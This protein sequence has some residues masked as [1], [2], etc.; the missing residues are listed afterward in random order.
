M[1]SQVEK[2]YQQTWESY[3]GEVAPLFQQIGQIS[4]EYDA[5]FKAIDE[6]LIVQL[7][8]TFTDMGQWWNDNFKITDAQLV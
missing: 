3:L 1:Y 6:N 2:M 7:D 5:K 8:D 4:D